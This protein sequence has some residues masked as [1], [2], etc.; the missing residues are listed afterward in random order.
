MWDM[1]VIYLGRREGV[2]EGMEGTCEASDLPGIL[3]RNQKTSVR[4][5]MEQWKATNIFSE[6]IWPTAPMTSVMSRTPTFV[7][8][9]SF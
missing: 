3:G 7:L 6:E 4:T 1:G 8:V 5:S 2:M 9:A